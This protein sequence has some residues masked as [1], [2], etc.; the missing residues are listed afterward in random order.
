MAAV[1]ILVVVV[2]F[3]GQAAACVWVQ[4][5]TGL[6]LVSGGSKAGVRVEQ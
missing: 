2:R 6:G 4:A 3:W 1:A 5:V